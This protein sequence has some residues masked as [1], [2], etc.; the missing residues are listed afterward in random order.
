M[1]LLEKYLI[2]H[3]APT[4]AGL[5]AANMFCVPYFSLFELKKQLDTWNS[6]LHEKG[7]FLTILSCNKNKILIYIFRR[8]HLQIDLQKPGVNSF[9]T[10]FGYQSNHVEYALKHLKKR[11]TNYNSFPHEIGIFLGYPLEDVVG[12]IKNSGKNCKYTGYWKVYCNERE[13]IKLFNRFEKCC[14]I[15]MQLWKQKKKT[16][17]QL[18]IAA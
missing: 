18:A 11:F 8:S 17:L 9:L 6:Y 5:K 13:T 3:C 4:L 10:A 2:R 12:F 14:R 7:L 16:V 1:I 15:Y